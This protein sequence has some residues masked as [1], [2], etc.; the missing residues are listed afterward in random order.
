MEEGGDRAPRVRRFLATYGD[1]LL[2]GAVVFCGLWPVLYFEA[3]WYGPAP[4]QDFHHW[5]WAMPISEFAVGTL[6]FSCSSRWM[7]RGLG[8]L[9]L[10]WVFPVTA[11]IALISLPL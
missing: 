4:W 11:F 9:S 7:V 2:V 3:N 6:A 8:C 5:G 1:G 10:L